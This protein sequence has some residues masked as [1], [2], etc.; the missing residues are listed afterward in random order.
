MPNDRPDRASR[1]ILKQRHKRPQWKKTPIKNREHI[2]YI[3]IRSGV[4]KDPET[5]HGLFGKIPGMEQS[6]VITNLQEFMKYVYDKSRQKTV[7]YRAALSFREDDAK[8]LGLINNSAAWEK[9]MNTHAAKFAESNRIPVSRFCWVGGVHMEK[10]HPHMH[11]VYWDKEQPLI[12]DDFVHPTV[13]NKVRIE[14]MK[15]VFAD[16]LEN[17]KSGKTEARN[18]LRKSGAAFFI[19]FEE[20]LD[21]MS[22]KEFERLKIKLAAVSAAHNLPPVSFG[23]FSENLL[24]ALAGKLMVLKIVLPK[25]GTLKYAYLPPDAKQA[26]DEVTRDLLSASKDISAVF[27]AYINSEVELSSFYVSSEKALESTR[28]KAYKAAMKMLGN[29]VLGAFKDFSAKEWEVKSDQY[30]HE[31][32]KELIFMLFSLLSSG[33]QQ[34]EAKLKQMKGGG[35]LSKQAKIELAKEMESKGLEWGD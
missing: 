34:N 4:I 30:R 16:D 12:K 10:G 5:G 31:C 23:K 15:D 25:G 32:V 33:V 3:A 27:E 8:T 1:V 29:K 28:K 24:S 18:A 35:D 11:L 26:V 9:L 22:G 7:F 20:A 2:R 21:N 14:I 17:L 6:G 13:L 19:G